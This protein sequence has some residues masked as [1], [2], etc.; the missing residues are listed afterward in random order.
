[1]H[2][3]HRFL[4]LMYQTLPH[5]LWPSHRNITESEHLPLNCRLIDVLAV[6][7]IMECSLVLKHCI[8]M[9]GRVDGGMS[10]RRSEFKLCR[11][12]TFLIFLP[13]VLKAGHLKSRGSCL[14]LNE[15]CSSLQV[16]HWLKMTSLYRW[17]LITCVFSNRPRQ[18]LTCR[19]PVAYLSFSPFV[20]DLHGLGQPLP[21]EGAKQKVHHRPAT[22]HCRWR[23]PGGSHWSRQ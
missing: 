3:S 15:L 9:Y 22:R 6:Y 12:R 1:M 19:S 7:L 11:P 21:G 4:L 16:V 18:E 23:P 5:E 14:L 13:K 8:E 20:A 10:L 2:L 17:P